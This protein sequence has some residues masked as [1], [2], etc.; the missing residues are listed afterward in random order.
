MPS[1]PTYLDISNLNLAS[2]MAHPDVL[3]EWYPKDQHSNVVF[4]KRSNIQKSYIWCSWWHQYMLTVWSMLFHTPNAVLLGSKKKTMWML[5]I[6]S[7]TTNSKFSLSS[8]WLM[9]IS[10]PA[11]TTTITGTLAVSNRWCANLLN[12]SIINYYLIN[13]HSFQQIANTV[14]IRFILK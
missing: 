2:K 11:G 3:L 13:Y 6:I 8:C 10:G 5:S 7:I 4:Y 9:M 14:R 12:R 1:V